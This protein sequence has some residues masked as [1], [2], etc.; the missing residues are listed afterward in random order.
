MRKH[1]MRTGDRYRKIHKGQVRM[2]SLLAGM[3]FVVGLGLMQVQ[4]FASSPNAKVESSNEVGIGDF[5]F[6]P[7]TLTVS[8]GT[9][10]TWTNRDDEA[11]TINSV[12]GAF[13]SSPLDTNDKF[14]FKFTA[15]GT[16]PYYC[17]LHPHMK[18]QVIVK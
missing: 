1:N 15:P 3:A 13:K 4:A 5:E 17:K 14:S 6:T 9:T 7:A 2:K 16:Y 8:V 10:V 18:G 12:T 11:H